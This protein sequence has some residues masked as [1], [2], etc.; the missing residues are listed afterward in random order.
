M[1]SPTLPFE[2]IML[3]LPGGFDVYIIRCEL[4][5]KPSADNHSIEVI[6]TDSLNITT[7]DFNS[8]ILYDN[9]T[10]RMVTYNFQILIT[11]S[12]VAFHCNLNFSLKR[13][14]NIIAVDE[15]VRL[16][17]Q[18]IFHLSTDT[19]SMLIN[20]KIIP[21]TGYF[22]VSV[23]VHSDASKVLRRKRSS[24]SELTAGALVYKPRVWNETAK[25]WL[26][27]SE[28]QVWFIFAFC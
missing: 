13:K 1:P 7:D 14:E 16:K 23:S 10:G 17:F 6:I 22:Y 26:P 5:R 8:S 4:E 2:Q 3:S 28:I 25:A 21:K 24:S 19:V 11:Q 18:Y 20:G 12:Y 9:S 15:I 27:S